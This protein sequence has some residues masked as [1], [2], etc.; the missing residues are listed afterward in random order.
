ML[1]SKCF[2][3]KSYVVIGMGKTGCSIYKSLI[4][5]GAVVYFWEDN[6]KHSKKILN[7]GYKKYSPEISH[8][9]YVLPSP[10]IAAK[11]KSAHKLI[12]KLTSKNT[13][14]ISEL[15]LFQLYLENLNTRKKIKIIAVTGT[16]GKST[17]VSL[18]YHTLKK[19]KFNTQLAG[20]IGN[21]IF[22]TKMIKKGFYVL[23]L[24]SYQLESSKIFQPDIACILNLTTDHLA[25]HNTMANYG[26]AKLNI[27]KNLNN[28]QKG[29]F[30][31]NSILKKLI[32]K[33][34]HLNKIKNLKQ[35]NNNKRSITKD[36]N[37]N[38]YNLLSNDQNYRFSY[39]ILKEVGL[40][41]NKIFN[42]FKSFR[43][44][45]FR[46]QIIFS[47]K[48]KVI[49]NDSKSTN[50]HSLIAALKKYKDIF[51]ICGG[52]IKS[53]NIN[54]LDDSLSNIKKVIIIGEESNTFYRYFKSKV[55]TVY[56]HSL[57]K[58]V[59]EMNKFMK[60]NTDFNTFLFSPGAASFDQY[61]NFEERGSHFNKLISK[62]VK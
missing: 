30:D 18:I 17:T 52:Q 22:E 36:L 9:D 31:N 7:K 41:S 3:K 10:G 28:S 46:Q 35:I 49:I 6:P 58:A 42:A 57:D 59:I 25:R 26:K 12:K 20:N 54:I 11:G 33:D 27:F 14:Q 53:S 50:Y 61:T 60:T 56:V 40:S 38:Q 51:L 37:I 47:D 23:E 39:E 21:P 19:N 1:K 34:N 29:F 13:K 16:N 32:K 24:S 15:D 43:G 62:L 45:E 2:S 8:I 44:L 5:S 4:N 48:N 55:A